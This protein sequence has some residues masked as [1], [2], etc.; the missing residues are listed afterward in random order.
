MTT[1]RLFDPFAAGRRVAARS[2][3]LI[4]LSSGR[5]LLGA[6]LVAVV[7]G[8]GIFAPL[9]LGLDPTTQSRDSLL[10]PSPGHLLGT[11]ELG[12]DLFA[13]VVHGIRV[14]ILIALIAAPLGAILGTIIGL[15]GTTRGILDTIVQR[16]FDVLYAFPGIILAVAVTAIF[17]PGVLAIIITTV[18]YS[19]PDFGRQVRNQVFQLRD[20]E[21]V[22]ASEV[23]GAS[24]L[25]ILF[26][27]ILPN[28]VDV[29]V[30]Q[31]ALSMSFAVFAEGGLSFI[32]LG[33]QLP[34]PSL[35][36]LLFGSLIYMSTHLN[37]VLTPM[38]PITL[39]VVGF[40][41]IG[42]GLNKSLLRR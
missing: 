4:A 21:F 20:R 19:I 22:V 5:G 36:N 7:A 26:R 24:S 2:R 28:A 25:R 35:G 31:L 3:Y 17:G 23:V 15:L 10:P 18:L 8:S 33:V 40:N 42:D 27:H 37:Y 6:I 14:D 38:I 30:V 13:R 29:L 41:L 34:E 32:G 1:S 16:T 11:D 9:F 39:L 12:R